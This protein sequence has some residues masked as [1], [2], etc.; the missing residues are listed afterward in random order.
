MLRHRVGHTNFRD[1]MMVDT[2][3]AADWA[4]A[5]FGIAS[6]NWAMVNESNVFREDMSQPW[7][8][9]LEEAVYTS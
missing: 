6:Y 3:K 9:R 1:L 4:I 8:N 5:F 7:K 2:K